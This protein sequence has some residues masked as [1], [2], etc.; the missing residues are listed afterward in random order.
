M[1]AGFFSTLKK[2]PGGYG[3]GVGG[4]GNRKVADAWLRPEYL[5]V[6]IIDDN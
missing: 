1:N 4:T 2:P 5:A 3:G 6:R